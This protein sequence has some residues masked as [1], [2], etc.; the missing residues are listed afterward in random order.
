MIA[1]QKQ[2]IRYLENYHESRYSDLVFEGRDEDAISLYDEIF[3]DQKEPEHYLF[4]SV[5]R[6][7]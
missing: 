2:L 5:T 7:R 6:I 1:N 3:I 4:V